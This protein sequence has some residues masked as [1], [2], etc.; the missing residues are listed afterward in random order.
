MGYLRE[1]TLNWRDLRGPVALDRQLH[2]D[3]TLRDAGRSLKLFFMD[4]PSLAR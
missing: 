4:E 3:T 2:G 1:E